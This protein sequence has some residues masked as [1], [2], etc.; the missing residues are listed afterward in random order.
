MSLA[1]TPTHPG[2]DVETEASDEDVAVRRHDRNALEFDLLRLV[3]HSAALEDYVFQSWVR[4]VTI[5]C[6]WWATNAWHSPRC[7]HC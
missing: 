7:S 5:W 2:L 1:P 4:S 3:Y 6:E